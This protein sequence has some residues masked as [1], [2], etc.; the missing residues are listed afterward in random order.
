MITPFSVYKTK[1]DFVGLLHDDNK[2]FFPIC[3]NLLCIF[4]KILDPFEKE[5]IMFEQNEAPIVG[6]FH[7]QVRY[8]KHYLDLYKNHNSDI[9]FLLP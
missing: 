9:C 3:E 5:V 4:K 8:F 7:K 1:D 6:L 2:L